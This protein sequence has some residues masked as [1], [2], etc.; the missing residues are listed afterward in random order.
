MQTNDQR[1]L[2][3]ILV[4][5]FLVEVPVSCSS[6]RRTLMKS[7]SPERCSFPLHFEAIRITPI[8]SSFQ[9]ITVF[10]WEVLKQGTGKYLAER[11][12]AQKRSLVMND[13]MWLLKCDWVSRPTLHSQPPRSRYCSFVLSIYSHEWSMQS[14]RAK[15]NSPKIVHLYVRC[16]PMYLPKVV[17][18]FIDK[19]VSTGRGTTILGS[20]TAIWR[21]LCWWHWTADGAGSGVEGAIPVDGDV[22]QD[23]H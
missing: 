9:S 1:V 2:E 3:I 8:I 10:L 20:A 15:Q 12:G 6:R 23:C 14:D 5:C 21:I 13:E 17:L 19:K 16:L 7:L 22:M 11:F 18:S 4:A